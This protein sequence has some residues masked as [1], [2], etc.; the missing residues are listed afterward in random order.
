MI[1][2]T[3]TVQRLGSTVVNIKETTRKAKKT[4]KVNTHGKMAV[5]IPVTGLIRK[6]LDMAS[7]FGLM[8]EPTKVTG[9]IIKCMVEAFTLG[10]MAEDMRVNISLTKNMDLEYNITLTEISTMVDGKIIKDTARVH[11]G[12]LTPKTNL[13][14][15]TQGIGTQI[16]NKE[17]V[18][19]STNLAIGMMECGW[20]IFLMEKAE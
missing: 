14:D 18:P 19:C 13:E 20:I 15:N 6:L 11:I 4:D 5:I 12:Q 8:E 3:V 2:S 1:I 7:M 10:R 16:K 9:L 17:E